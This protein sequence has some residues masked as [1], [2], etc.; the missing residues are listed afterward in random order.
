ML[1]RARVRAVKR[2]RTIVIVD[3][4]A[5]AKEIRQQ[6]KPFWPFIKVVAKNSHVDWDSLGYPCGSQC[7]EILFDHFVLEQRI[8]I[9]TA[10]IERL[11][12][13]LAKLQEASHEFDAE[14]GQSS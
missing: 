11:Q 13:Q 2:E 6:V 7:P 10:E 1:E 5:Y 8:G 3:H 14:P 9:V 12:K 4:E